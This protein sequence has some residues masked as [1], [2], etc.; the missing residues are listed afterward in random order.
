[1]TIAQRIQFLLLLAF[2]TQTALGQNNT[3]NY[4]ES[5]DDCKKQLTIMV[6]YHKQKAYDSAAKSWRWCFNNCPQG[7]KNIYIVGEKI[8]SKK[9]KES[10]DNKVLR[11]TY[12]DTLLQIYDTRIQY[13]PGKT[14]ISK[15]KILGKKGKTIASYKAKTN[16]EEAYNTL[17]S[18][19]NKLGTN[20]SPGVASAY[21]FTVKKMLKNNKLNCSDMILAYTKVL[22]IVN[23]NLEKKP[24]SYK[25][26][27]E[28]AIK[29][30]DKCLDCDLLDSLY[31]SDFEKFQGDTTWL[32]GGIELLIDKKCKKSSILVKMMEKRYETSP[33]AKTAIKLAQYFGSKGEN[34]KATQF[35]KEGILMEKDSN[36]LVKYYLKNARFL[37]NSGNSS[38]GINMAKKALAIQ[39][40]NAKA[41]LIMGDAI[42]YGAK[43]CKDLKFKGSE[44][45]WVAV[46]YYNK[47]A[48]LAITPE[49]KNKATKNASKYSAYFPLTNAIF[50]DKDV[51]EGATYKVG[52]WIN[53]NTIVRHKQ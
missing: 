1:M 31:T 8:F 25:R 33:S 11:A 2:T 45:Y 24:K 19:V 27:K 30:A 34:A 53:I 37:N 47:A 52:C 21:I 51:K 29:T 38:G 26:L 32:D 23:A 7:S 46:D 16:Y 44:V 12:I 48:A 5:A 20:V 15:Y 36:K 10:K 3:I 39:P 18:V 13:F 43:S 40:K 9:I 6:T 17:D 41:Y 4:G 42:I 49:I 28:K 22:D 35:F 14:E 50:M